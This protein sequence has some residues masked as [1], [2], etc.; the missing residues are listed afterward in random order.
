MN[1]EADKLYQLLPA[2]YRIRDAE[3][4]GALR[5]LCEVLA[6]DIAALRENLDQLYDDQFIETC[7]D[8]SDALWNLSSRRFSSA[9]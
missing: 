2:I 1:S 3:Q 8:S 7:A 9:R 6:E 4:N 5:A